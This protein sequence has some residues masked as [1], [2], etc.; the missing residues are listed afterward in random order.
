MI[1]S[2]PCVVQ[3]IKH[4][5]TI[6]SE[7]CS[8]RLNCLLIASSAQIWNIILLTCLRSQGSMTLGLRAVPRSRKDEIHTCLFQ[9]T[10][11]MQ[12]QQMCMLTRHACTHEL[13]QMLGY[14]CAIIAGS[15]IQPH[16]RIP[17]S[18]F[19]QYQMYARAETYPAP[20]GTCQRGNLVA[21]C[22]LQR[23]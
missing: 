13:L 4:G 1:S 10:V 9:A 15:C 6:M 8:M 11:W 3:D 16:E 23:K 14:T 20:H 5:A 18:K 17:C 7:P 22:R 12:H 2:C 19:Q 21:S